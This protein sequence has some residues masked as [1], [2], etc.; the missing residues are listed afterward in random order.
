MI[1]ENKMML[2]KYIPKPWGYENWIT[3]QPEYAAKIIFIKA[4]HKLSLQY[5]TK[6]KETIYLFQGSCKMTIDSPRDP[7]TPMISGTLLEGELKT[8]LFNPGECFEI[9]PRK[10]HR[11]EAIHD[12]TIF[13]ISTPELDDVIRIEDDY[14]RV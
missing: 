5:H 1:I 10:I 11:I 2:P 8:F 12:S 3:I 4:G 6:K 14:G 9:P 13:E 7:D